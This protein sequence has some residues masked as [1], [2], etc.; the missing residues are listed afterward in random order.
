MSFNIKNTKKYSSTAAYT[1][2]I[3]NQHSVVPKLSEYWSLVSEVNI[4]TQ[5]V[6]V[7]EYIQIKLICQQFVGENTNILFAQHHLLWFS[8]SPHPLKTWAAPQM[9]YERPEDVWKLTTITAK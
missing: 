7:S 2:A 8:I 3:T 9:I 4:F 6:P 1:T 5:S